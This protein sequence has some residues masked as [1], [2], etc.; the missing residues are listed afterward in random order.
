MAGIVFPSGD[1]SQGSAGEFCFPRKSRAIGNMQTVEET[2]R[3]RLK[4]LVDREGGLAN[5]CALLGLSRKETPGLSRILNANVRHERGGKPY[6]MGSPLARDIESRL[7]LPEGWMDTPATYAELEN[8]NDPRAMVM[9]LMEA[10]PTSEWATVVRLVDALAQPA[11]GTTG[12][13][14]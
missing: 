9:T 1:Y 8:Q 11:N 2:R 14:S 4:A 13:N 3:Q 10:M 7:G 6:V 12:K 5:L